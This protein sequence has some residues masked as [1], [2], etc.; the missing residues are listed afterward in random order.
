MSTPLIRNA[1]GV[2]RERSGDELLA[3]GS[4]E[5][6][7][8]R[9]VRTLRIQQGLSVQQAAD[10]VGVSKAMLSKIENNQTSASLG[11]LAKLAHGL[12]VPVTSLFR[13]VDVEREAVFVA[14]GTGSPIVRN[15]SRSGHLYESLG[16]L[17]GQHQRLEAL[18][19]T[20]D[21]RSETYPLFQH[22]GTEVIYVLAGIMEYGHGRTVHRL[23]PGDSLIFDGEGAHGP[24][25]LVELPIRFL[26]MIA[27]P[28]ATL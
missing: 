28:D 8:G 3:A 9:N 2:T 24:T 27:F 19:V 4:L 23:Q 10:R 25:T 17:H 18:L 1:V 16:S 7:I 21:A 15:G 5:E 13:D 6:A 14:A 20:L 22:P 11:T 12:D 26:S